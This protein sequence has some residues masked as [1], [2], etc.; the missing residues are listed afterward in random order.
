MYRLNSALRVFLVICTLAFTAEV[1]AGSANL[2]G[3]A[4]QITGDNLNTVNQSSPGMTSDITGGSQPHTNASTDLG[5][6]FIISLLTSG[7]SLTGV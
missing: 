2:G 4:I 1:Q 3:G 7:I 5:L 6:S